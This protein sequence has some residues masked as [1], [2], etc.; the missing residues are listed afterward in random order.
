MVPCAGPATSVTTSRRVL[1]CAVESTRR[2]PGG[3]HGGSDYATDAGTRDRSLYRDC[4]GQ[5]RRPKSG[6]SMAASLLRLLRPQSPATTLRGV[7]SY[8]PCGPMLPLGPVCSACYQQIRT[9]PHPCFQCGESR[10]L[11]G[12]ASGR[13]RTLCAAVTTTPVDLPRLRCPRCSPTRGRC[14]RCTAQEELDVCDHAIS[15]E[16]E[17]QNRCW[18]TS[19]SRTAP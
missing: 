6:G 14:P 16:A 15:D 4:K 5:A 19:T 9:K 1:T 10:P 7:R 8:R 2:S 17:S 3:D 12:I 18:T 13:R 11:V